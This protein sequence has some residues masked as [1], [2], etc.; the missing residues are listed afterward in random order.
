M[1]TVALCASLAVLGWP[2]LG[3]AAALVALTWSQLRAPAVVQLA[4][5]HP[6]AE[7]PPLPTVPV[8]AVDAGHSAGPDPVPVDDE[9]VRG[10]LSAQAQTADLS[11]TFGSGRQQAESLLA[12][13]LDLQAPVARTARE[14]ESA[15]SLS[16]QIFGQVQALEVSSD[17]IS[18][19]VE[20]IRRIASQTNL[21]ALNATIEASRAGEAGRGFAVVAAEVRNLAQEARKATETIDGI[22]ADLKE[23]TSVTL[24]MAESTSGQVEE[25][26]TSM[27]GVVDSIG[28]A[29]AQESGA[30]QALDEAGS[31]AVQVGDALRELVRITEGRRGTGNA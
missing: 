5:D 7:P 21:L 15:R 6:P 23:M 28:R 8:R 30:R 9:L 12:E 2:V 11:L 26:T 22:V 24:E 25:A 27:T 13:L 20:S 4:P 18:G 10:V 1:P 16:F 31:R 17:E 19:V 29:Q 14:L 3:L